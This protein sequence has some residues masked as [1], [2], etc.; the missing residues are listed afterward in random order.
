MP[1]M[2]IHQLS[3][4]YQAEQDRLLLRVSSTS[5]QEMRL[6]LTRRL[7]LGLWPLISRLQTEQLLKL[8]AAGSALDGAD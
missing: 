4:S 5:G 8:E 6:W 1:R 7:M 3:V 2:Q